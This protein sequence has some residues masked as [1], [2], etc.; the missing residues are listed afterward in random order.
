MRKESMSDYESISGQE[1]YQIMKDLCEFG[2]RRAGTPIA[3]KAENYIYQKLKEAKLPEVKLD[4]FKFTRW[5]AEKQELRLIADGTPSIP[6]DQII[7]TFPVH[8]SGFTDPEGVI[9][10]MV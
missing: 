1:M 4:E 7:E 6:S 5:W 9:A 8:L 2:Y 3:I 10:E